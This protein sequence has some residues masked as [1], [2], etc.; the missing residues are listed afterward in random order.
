MDE[1][2]AVRKGGEPDVSSEAARTA[3]LTLL[4]AGVLSKISTGNR[5]QVW[6]AR[7]LP[8]CRAPRCAVVQLAAEPQLNQASACSTQRLDHGRNSSLA[9]PIGWPHSSQ[10]P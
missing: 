5:N 3:I 7:E 1:L 10:S 9:S 2:V 4:D 6:V 8:M